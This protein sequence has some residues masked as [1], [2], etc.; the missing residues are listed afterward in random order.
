MKEETAKRLFIWLF[1]CLAVFKVFLVADLE[2]FGQ[3]FDELGYARSIVDH[4]YNCDPA[5][6]WLFIRPLGFPIFGAICMESGIPYRVCIEVF[7]LA[8]TAFFCRALIMVFKGPMIPLLAAVGL[9]F[10]PWVLTGFNQ[11]LTEPFY[12]CLILL[13]LGLAIRLTMMERLRFYSPS[14][15]VLGLLMAYM[16]LTRRESPWIFGVIVLIFSLRF[17]RGYLS[18]KVGMGRS[19]LALWLIALPILT[20]QGSLFLVSAANYQ[21]WGIFATN[22]QEAPGFSKLLDVLYRIETPDPSLWAPVTRQTL[23]MAMAVS[24]RFAT[25][26]EG[27]ENPHTANMAFGQQTT[28]RPGELGAWMWW[29]LYSSV[30]EAGHYTSPKAANAWMLETAA[31]LEAAFADGRLPERSFS[32]PFPIDPNFANWLPRF[33]GLFMD[34]LKRFHHSGTAFAFAEKEAEIS[35]IDR[36]YFDEAANRRRHLLAEESVEVVGL[37][38]ASTGRLDHLTVEDA[39]GQTVAAA[40][41]DGE[42]NWRRGDIRALTG[43][44]EIF[45][46]AFRMQF[47]PRT[48]GPYTLSLWKDGQQILTYPLRQRSFPHRTITQPGANLP[49]ADLTIMDYHQPRGRASLIEAGLRGWAFSKEGRLSHLT[50]SDPEGKELLRCK[51]GFPRPDVEKLFMD[52][53]GRAADGPLGFAADMSLKKAPPI[54]VNFWKDD[55]LVHT[56][57]ME[58]LT[59]GYWGTIDE[60]V[61]GIPLVVGIGYQQLPVAS[62]EGLNWRV[63]VREFLAGHYL[64]LLLGLSALMAALSAMGLAIRHKPLPFERLDLVLLLNLMGLFLLG[65]AAFYGLVEAAVVPGVSRYMDCIS[66]IGAVFLALILVSGIF[67]ITKSFQ[68]RSIETA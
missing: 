67:A 68:S 19:I 18:G 17:A 65:R 45:E 39:S 5:A 59:R 25:L 3:R 61:S 1:L 22:E 62:N 51:V 14:L 38:F 63:E 41:P 29:Q 53:V 48:K 11:L 6:N 21:K 4:Y 36:P 64:A 30:A 57:P 8:C 24:P 31:E 23:E 56:L 26:R 9:V 28:G 44:D 54:T 46:T 32:T 34:T 50:F 40:A 33:P 27:L 20:Y 55:L 42:V 16:M 15:Y 2:V 52:A 60:T 35:A 49:A 13:L 7:F 43:R 10:H 58:E 47:Y 66:P 12:L 37:A